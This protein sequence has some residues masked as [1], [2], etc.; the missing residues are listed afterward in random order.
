MAN[1]PSSPQTS[2]ESGPPINPEVM[3]SRPS[4]Y[5]VWAILATL[6]CCLPTGIVSIIYAAQVNSKWEGGDWAGAREASERAKM[7]ALISLI[8]GVVF[9]VAYYGLIFMSGMG[10]AYASG[11]Q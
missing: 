3:T 9:S 4:N 10:D 7:W 5:L 8:L 2:P 6:C 11:A 1:F